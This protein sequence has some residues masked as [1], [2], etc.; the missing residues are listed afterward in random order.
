VAKANPKKVASKQGDNGVVNAEPATVRGR[1]TLAALLKSAREIF[2]RDGFVEARI[3]DIVDNAG[4]AYGSFYT[5]FDSKEAIFREVALAMA[6]DMYE[7]AFPSAEAKPADR[8]DVFMRL[9]QANR[10]YIQAYA[11]NAKIWAVVHQMATFNEFAHQLWQDIRARFIDRAAKG[12]IRLQEADLANPDNLL[13]G[14]IEHFAYL[15]LALGSGMKKAEEDKFVR[16]ITVLW[17]GAIG[18]KTD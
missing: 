11:K 18:L 17:A 4:V 12:M 5:Y 3:T 6:Q 8:G 7:A 1:N 9:E 16:A 15:T 10:R 14:M 2:E 13:G